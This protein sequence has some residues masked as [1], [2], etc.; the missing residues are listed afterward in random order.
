LVKHFSAP[1]QAVDIA[2]LADAL[3]RERGTGD[4]AKKPPA[5]KREL[6]RPREFRAWTGVWRDPWFGDVSLCAKGRKVYFVAAKSPRL[7]G[8][9]YRADGRFLVDWDDDSVDAEPWLD[10][11]AAGEGGA[12]ATLALA[13]VDPEADFSYDYA[14]L[15]FTR[16]G[17]C[18]P[19]R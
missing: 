6:V 15:A 7:S 8:P 16:V 12:P 10:F 17:D 1:A 2:T 18:K 14:D 13:H 4:A 5:P 9:V 19:A 3:A 11:K